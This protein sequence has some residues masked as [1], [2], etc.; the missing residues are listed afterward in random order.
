MNKRLVLKRVAEIGRSL[1]TEGYHYVVNVNIS[2]AIYVKM[3]H[4]KNGNF[5]TLIGNYST[6]WIRTIKNGKTVKLENVVAH[7]VSI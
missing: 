3:R 2:T 6:G 1:I 7:V 4:Q 5:I